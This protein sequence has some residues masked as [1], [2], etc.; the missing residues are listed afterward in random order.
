MQAKTIRS[1]ARQVGRAESTVRKWIARDDWPFSLAPSWDVER[2]K[3]WAEIHLNPDPAAAYRKKARAAEMGTGEFAPMGPLTRAKL[4]ATIERALL[5]RQRRLIE[6]GEL[7]NVKDCTH[8]RLRQI[9]E[10]KTRLMELPRAMASSMVGQSSEV[11]E[12][13]M[14]RQLRAIIE[15]FATDGG[16]KT[17]N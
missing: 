16:K 9:H 6:A 7:H 1:L 10:V 2:V 15:D 3:A 5:I 14:N 11:I 17:E 13:I 4:Q 12:T 8:R